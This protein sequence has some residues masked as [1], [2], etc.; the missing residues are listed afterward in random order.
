MVGDILKQIREENKLTQE[1]I[2]T[3]LNIKRQTYSSYE[4]NISLPDINVISL[5]A[6]YYRTST[7]YLLGR[8]KI[9]QPPEIID[10]ISGISNEEM[11]LIENYR[12]L[13]IETRAELRGEIKGILRS[14]S[15]ETTTTIEKSSSNKRAI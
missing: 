1:N 11:Q 10:S 13:T 6:D 15:Q 4:R 14:T 9:K 12:K 2:A 3:L 8:T 7:D 5:L